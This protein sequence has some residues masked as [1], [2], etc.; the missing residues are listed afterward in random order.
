CGGG[1]LT[2]VADRGPPGAPLEAPGRRGPGGFYSRGVLGP[3]PTRCGASL[4]ELAAAVRRLRPLAT[5][6]ARLGV[7]PHAPYTVSEPLYRATAELAR[8]E[9]LPV[10]VHLAESREETALVR[11]G[12]GPFADAVRARGIPVPAHNCTPVQSRFRLGAS[13]R[14]PG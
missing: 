7:S 14:A 12:A 4:G 9:R 11:D 13:H 5:G 3:D 8:R 1:G 10:A 2:W 6:R